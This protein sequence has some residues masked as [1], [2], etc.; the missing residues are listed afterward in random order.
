MKKTKGYVFFVLLWC[1]AVLLIGCA[2]FSEWADA[3]YELHREEQAEAAEARA[4]A[5]EARGRTEN[6]GN[7]GPAGGLI[8]YD[9]GNDDDGWQYMEV[10]PVDAEFEAVWGGKGELVEF[11]FRGHTRGEGN[12]T[13]IVE[14]LGNAEPYEGRTDYAAKAAS[15]L[16]YGGYSDWFLPSIE[17][18]E[19]IDRFL[20]KQGL[21]DFQSYSV[22]NQTSKYYLSSSES[23]EDEAYAIYFGFSS[24]GRD[25]I[26]HPYKDEPYLVRPVRKF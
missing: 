7:V 16:S 23:T 4:E 20:F 19:N 12:T 9:K 15:E 18:L 22:S 14:V 6:L 2:S 1:A 11:T 10:A 13:R 17:N 24:G 8:F 25:N 21:G 3:Q 5:E 26:F